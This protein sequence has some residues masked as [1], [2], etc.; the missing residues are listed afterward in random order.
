MGAGV[1]AGSGIGILIGGILENT[2]LGIGI[3]LGLGVALG[4]ALVSLARRR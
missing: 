4:A 3:G 2:A 1:L